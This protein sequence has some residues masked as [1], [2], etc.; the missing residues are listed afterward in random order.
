[1]KLKNNDKVMLKLAAFVLLIITALF[2][3]VLGATS[4]D[5]RFIRL[6]PHLYIPSSIIAYYA[7]TVIC[8]VVLMVMLSKIDRK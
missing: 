8:I 4:E 6:D 7:V 1:M 3:I 2:S 5:I